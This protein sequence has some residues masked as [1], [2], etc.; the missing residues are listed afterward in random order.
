MAT[1]REFT[2]KVLGALREKLLDLT[3]RN[4][5]LNYKHSD[6]ARTHIRV[7]DEITVAIMPACLVMPDSAI[8][9]SAI[10]ASKLD[11]IAIKVPMAW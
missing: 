5:T 10:W 7:I 11:H 8:I 2:E 6:R 4:R 1:N 3:R 9:P